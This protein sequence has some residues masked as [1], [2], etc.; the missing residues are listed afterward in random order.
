MCV[1]PLPGR[2]PVSYF[3]QTPVSSCLQTLHMQTLDYFV[4]ASYDGIILQL[5]LSSA[6]SGRTILTVPIFMQGVLR[7]PTK[8]SS[9]MNGFALFPVFPNFWIK[10]NYAQNSNPICRFKYSQLKA[11]TK[12]SFDIHYLLI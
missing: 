5:E 4:S 8:T 3:I 12:H 11:W 7:I 9:V 6:D 1:R 2:T 10:G